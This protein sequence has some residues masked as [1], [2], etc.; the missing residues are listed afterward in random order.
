MSQ[1]FSVGEIV[2]IG[3]QFLAAIVAQDDDDPWCYW[4]D[5]GDGE[6]YKIKAWHIQRR[7]GGTMEESISYQDLDYET[8]VKLPHQD[9][10]V[11][12]KCQKCLTD[13]AE[14]D[15]NDTSFWFK[16]ALCGTTL[17]LWSKDHFTRIELDDE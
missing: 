6:P 10:M 4:V 14:A 16:C 15:E 1:K 3:E 2:V 5:M 11:Q 7:N 17:A 13:E 12:I 8:W 9:E